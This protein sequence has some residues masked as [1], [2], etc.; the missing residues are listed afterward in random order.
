MLKNNSYLLEKFHSVVRQWFEATYQQPTAIQ[1]EAWETISQGKNTLVVAPTGSGKT[2]AAFLWAIQDLLH[3]KTEALAQGVN[4]AKKQN[5]GVKVLYISPLKALGADVEKNLQVPLSA[6]EALW[7]QGQDETCPDFD[8]CLL[9]TALRTGDTTPDERRKILAHPPDILIT[10]PESLYLMLTS[11]A[12]SVLKTVQTVIVDEI[13]SLVPNKRGAHLSLSLE[14]LDALLEKPAQRIGL[15]ATVNPVSVVAQYLGGIHPVSVVQDTQSQ[16]FDLSIHVPVADM[17]AVPKNGGSV[18]VTSL[19]SKS[20]RSTHAGKDAWKTD[21]TLKAALAAKEQGFGGAGV[22]PDERRGSSSLW[23]YI[24]SALLDEILAHRSTI[25][26]VNSRGLCERLTARLN[27]LQAKRQGLSPLLPQE[28]PAIQDKSQDGSF[29]SM[30]SDIGSTS[31]LVTPADNQSAIAK[32]HHG[33]V[34]KEKRLQV[35]AELKSGQLRCVV[36]TSSLELGIDMGSVDLVLQVAPPLSVASGLQRIGRANHQVKGRSQAIMYPRTRLE[37]LDGVVVAKAMREGNLEPLE[38]VENALDVLAQQ[39]IA[40]VSQTS[41]QACDWYDI[42]R[43]SACYSQLSEQAYRKVLAMV[44]GYYSRGDLSDFAPRIDWDRDTDKLSARANS[45]RLA[46]SGAGTI[47]DRGLFPV[48]LP[49]GIGKAGRKRVGELDEEMVYESRVGDVIALGTSSWRIKEITA[50]RVMVEPAPGHIARLPFWH[51]EQPGRAFELGC[52]KGAFVRQLMSNLRE[53]DPEAPARSQEVSNFT[54]SM[55]QTL[56][57]IGLDER[58]RR[59]LAGL[60]RSQQAATQWVPDDQTLVVE[61]CQDEMGQWRLF[62]HSPFGKS[63]HEPWALAVSWRV[64]TEWGYDP[65][66]SASDD[67]IMLQIP[68]TET[69]FPDKSIFEFDPEEIASIVRGQV[70]STALFAARFRECAMRSLL[71][72]AGLHGKRAPLWQQRIKAGQLLEGA[73]QEQGFPLLTE[74]ARECLAD[75][76]NLQA[77]Q[78]VQTQIAAGT[79]KL[80][81]VTTSVPS[82]FAASLVFAY[83]GEHLYDPDK[84][85]SAQQLA[86]LSLDTSL[87]VELLGGSDFTDLIDEEVLDGLIAK[88]QRL[89]MPPSRKSAETIEDL[90]RVLGPLSFN[91]LCERMADCECAEIEGWLKELEEEQRV[92]PVTLGGKYWAQPQDRAWLQALTSTSLPDWV[93]PAESYSPEQTRKLLDEELIRYGKTHGPFSARACASRLGLGSGIVEAELRNLESQG[94][95]LTGVFCSNEPAAQW[96]HKDILARLRKLSLTAAR[97]AVEP[98]TF[99]RYLSY[100]FDLQNVASSTFLPADSD[101]LLEIIAHFEGCSLPLALWEEVIFPTRLKSYKPA[102]LD[103]LLEAG[104]AFWQQQGDNLAFYPGD[105]PFGPQPQD[106]LRMTPLSEEEILPAPSLP[107]AEAL[108]TVLSCKGPLLYADLLTHLSLYGNYGE[109]EVVAA[110]NA[111]CSQGALSNDSFAFIRA[112]ETDDLTDALSG[113]SAQRAPKPTVSRR[114]RLNL[115]GARRLKQEARSVALAHSRRTQALMGHWY[116]LQPTEATPEE[117]ALSAVESVLDLYGVITPETVKLSGVSVEWSA[118]SKVLRT[119]E[120]IGTL[121]RGC[122]VEELGPVQYAQKETVE[123]LQE[124]SGRTRDSRRPNEDVSWV[125]LA[126]NDPAQCYGLLATWPNPVDTIAQKALLSIQESSAAGSECEGD[127]KRL[128]IPRTKDW[129]TVFCDGELLFA[130]MTSFKAAYAFSDDRSLIQQAIEKVI[131]AIQ[132]QA[133]QKGE[134]LS[135]KKIVAKTINGREVFATEYAQLLLGCGFVSLP[136]GLRYYPQPF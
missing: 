48:V 26:F 131:Q 92:F 51:G 120:E 62:L 86:L 28:S 38:L 93:G 91:E 127:L 107:V 2:L 35:E 72:G 14:R 20:S 106:S 37:L 78:W 52:E 53:P 9:R 44:S 136:D 60:L 4:L 16:A 104:D 24:E 134:S 56:A 30:R 125:V 64:Q 61:H 102:S 130:A 132:S 122:F 63:V 119:M 50:D 108:T 129:L 133:R 109:N 124:G 59:N 5:Q 99:K 90:L 6:I 46:V 29:V 67:G 105:S 8:G 71:M 73:R 85:K 22:P 36:A 21:R 32:A 39:T 17:A 116:L 74:A 123:V 88:L 66:A 75:V 7:L 57:D 115:S 69:T 70:D 54:D 96:I 45:Q 49:E 118:L 25:V 87:L 31:E 103:L 65:C 95:F 41:Y 58:G 81:D 111:L 55:T 82:P 76:Y 117:I 84:P 83:V 94:V 42:V 113:S 40:A 11:Q 3:A 33:S 101:P 23:P 89:N 79:I 100:V 97:Q 68:L 77:L 80:H 19:S 98:V 47:P 126:A 114:G 34:S 27:E 18:G 121:Q 1:N 135:R 112:Q 10:T 15:S 43:K 12:S 13:H 128:R 110:L